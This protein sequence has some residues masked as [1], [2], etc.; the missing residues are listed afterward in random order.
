MVGDR[1][2]GAVLR[3]GCL[4]GLSCFWGKRKRPQLALWPFSFK[5][6]SRLP[7][8]FF[9]ATAA[10]ATATA[11]TA[12][13]AGTTAAA[14]IAATAAAALFTRTGFVYVHLA[15][16]HFTAIKSL[17]CI[18][19]FIAVRHF[20]EG[21]TTGLT[22]FT[23][24]DKAHTL[25][26]AKGTKSLFQFIFSCLIGKVANKNIRHCYFSPLRGRRPDC[27][28]FTRSETKPDPNIEEAAL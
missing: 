14:T 1:A 23:V 4:A 18:L 10:T 9:A 19:G 2:L 16:V 13:A 12:A 15:T 3:C 24:T 25:N 28:V 20:D 22:G 6:E 27:P 21:K 11:I 5:L 7:A 26:G 17:N 8:G